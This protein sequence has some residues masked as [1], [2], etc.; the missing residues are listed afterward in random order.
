M[1]LQNWDWEGGGVDFRTIRRHPKTTLPLSV[2]QSGNDDP[3]PVVSAAAQ[4]RVSV[5]PSW[6]GTDTLFGRVWNLFFAESSSA[7]SNSTAQKVVFLLPGTSNYPRCPA[8]V[9]LSSPLPRL[10]LIGVLPSAATPLP[11]PA[12]LAL[13]LED[14]FLRAAANST[15]GPGTRTGESLLHPSPVV[16]P[17]VDPI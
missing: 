9:T 2:L 10:L 3:D 16:H 1:Q 17:K 6:R 13:L 7:F 4:C 8:V 5:G 15:N 12:S 14:I 11:P